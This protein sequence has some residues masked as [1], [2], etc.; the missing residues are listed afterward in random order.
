[1]DPETGHS[2]CAKHFDSLCVGERI[3]IG[4][5]G[6]ERIE[7]RVDQIQESLKFLGKYLYDKKAQ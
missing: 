2:L 1:M 7:E 5:L 6:V 4:E 3:A